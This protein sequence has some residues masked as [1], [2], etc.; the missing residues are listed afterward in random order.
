MQPKHK[1]TP[2]YAR[3]HSYH[4]YTYPRHT[5]PTIIATQQLAENASDALSLSHTNPTT[6]M[7]TLRTTTRTTMREDSYNNHCVLFVF[8]GC[9]ATTM[10]PRGA[11]RL[12]PERPTSA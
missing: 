12:P 6:H 1:K 9:C 3:T 8:R 10:H 5:L 7:Q 2:R 11:V 4:R